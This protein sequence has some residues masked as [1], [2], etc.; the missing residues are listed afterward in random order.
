MHKSLSSSCFQG[1]VPQKQSGDMKK[2]IS[3]NAL[4]QIEFNTIID[5]VV[6]TKTPINQAVSCV[7]SNNFPQGIIDNK[8]TPEIV[9]CMMTPC[10]PPRQIENEIVNTPPRNY[11]E[12]AIDKE[13]MDRYHTWLTRIRKHKR[14]NREK[15]I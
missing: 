4:P 8:P 9:T 12:L 13:W 3:T 2:S 10:E 14:H 15:S 11:L 5:A 7:V 6:I 1:L